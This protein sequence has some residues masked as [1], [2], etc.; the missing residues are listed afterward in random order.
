[1][2]PEQLAEKKSMWSKVAIFLLSVAVIGQ[3]S[4]IYLPAFIGQSPDPNSYIGTIL[5]ISLLFMAIWSWQGKKKSKGFVFGVLT[6]LLVQFFAGFIAAY[7]NA[8]ESA[9][10][11]AVAK[12][13]EKL[14]RV[15]DEETRL[16]SAEIDQ[17]S[18]SYSLKMTTINYIASEIDISVLNDNFYQSTKPSTCNISE[19]KLFFSEGYTINF[20]YNDKNGKFISKYNVT[21][22]DCIK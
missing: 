6:A 21:P 19:F 14:P 20:I 12:S 15:I 5:W 7:L 13:N 8:E 22:A 16:D 2:K 10:D 18:K 3:I 9:I 4:A 11:I 1:M 17:K